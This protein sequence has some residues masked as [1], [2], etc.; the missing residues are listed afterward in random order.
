MEKLPIYKL[1]IN[2]NDPSGVEYVAL[3]DNPAIERNWI[4]FSDDFKRYDHKFKVTNEEKRI[5]SGALM[6]PDMPIYRNDDIIGEYYAVFDA[7]TIMGIAQ[8]YFKN[9][10]TSNVNLMH[11]PSKAV[12]GVYM[13]ESFIID[14]SRGIKS[15]EGF[16][17]L[18][19]GSWFGSFKVENDTVWSDIKAGQFKGFSIEGTF[20]MNQEMRSQTIDIENIINEIL[21]LKI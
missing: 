11:D 21:A 3:V 13:F 1:T 2:E 8:K 7:A 4:A 9:K 20:L 12:E 18:T 5:I 14:S 6:V 10:F 16:G 15:P 19:N 17:E